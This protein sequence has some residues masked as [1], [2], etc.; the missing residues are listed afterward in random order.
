MKP[1]RMKTPAPASYGQGGSRSEADV[2]SGRPESHL[3]THNFCDTR[4]TRE[5]VRVG[6]SYCN[7]RE[8]QRSFSERQ[9]QQGTAGRKR[10][11]G[12]P[13]PISHELGEHGQVGEPP[14]AASAAEAQRVGGLLQRGGWRAQLQ[15]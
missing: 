7:N 1:R 9:P 2:E 12:R 13:G 10:T 15:L 6:L 8:V 14:G 3:F 4:G 11:R 5:G